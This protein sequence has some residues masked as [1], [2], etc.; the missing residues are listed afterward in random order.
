[1][2]YYAVL[3]DWGF[4]LSATQK[5]ARASNEPEALRRLFWGTLNAKI[6]LLLL[7]LSLL[8]LTTI[9]IPALRT[10]WSAMLASSLNVIAAA[11]NV[12]WFLQGT[13]FMGRFAASALIGR[14]LII[15]LTLAFVHGP[16]DVWKAVAIQGSTL[17]ISAVVSMVVS[18]RIAKLTTFEFRLSFA[19]SQ[20]YDGR[21]QFI[22]NLSIGV[23]TQIGGIFVGFLSG[24]IQLGLLT[25]SQ[26]ISAAFQGLVVPINLAIYPHII[27]LTESDPPAAVRLMFRVLVGQSTLS[28]CISI[29]MYIFAPFI[30]P[31][32]L[33]PDFMPAIAIV[34]VF[35][36]LPFLAGVGNVLGLDML[37]PLGLK[38]AYTRSL[39]RAGAVNIVLLLLLAKPFGA[40]GGAMSS[41]L[42]EVALV[43][44][45]GRALYVKRAIFGRM[46]NGEKP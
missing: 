23:Y 31:R 33:G 2:Y 24:A 6:G 22:S 39:V 13:Q 40:I 27:A 1:V 19:W 12:N 45:M 30:V 44:M 29:V 26:R 5:I 34:K 25:G 10:I 18:A 4:G 7:S 42:T 46:R 35:A 28:A 14:L 41:I 11:F 36:F 3:V 20:L 8:G 37:L 21:H 9:S 16:E 15:P 43:L 17:L 32:F 38:S